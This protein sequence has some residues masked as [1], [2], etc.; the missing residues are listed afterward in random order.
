MD[1]GRG[2]VN[3]G[4]PALTAALSKA[5]VIF[6]LF[7]YVYESAGHATQADGM[8]PVAEGVTSNSLLLQL[9]A[10][11]A[12]PLSLS[13]GGRVAGVAHLVEIAGHSAKFRTINLAR[14][15]QVDPTT[16]SAH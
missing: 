2:E 7:G 15:P 3:I 14:S 11:E 12:V 6:G 16:V 5:G 4:D 8:T 13:D 1:R 10:V 9:G